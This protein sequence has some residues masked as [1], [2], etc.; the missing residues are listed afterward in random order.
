MNPHERPHDPKA[1]EFIRHADREIGVPE[2]RYASF[3]RLLSEVEEDLAGP[4]YAET[5]KTMEPVLLA[6]LD[7]A[8]ELASDLDEKKRVEAL[9]QEVRRG[10]GTAPVERPH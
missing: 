7:V 3:E 2:A 6:K 1:A 8:E 4:A 10:S 5:Q 9:R